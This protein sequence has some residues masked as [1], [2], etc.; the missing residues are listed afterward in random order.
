LKA[1]NNEKENGSLTYLQREWLSTGYEQA[2]RFYI[3]INDFA[4]NN[5]IRARC[6]VTELG[7]ISGKG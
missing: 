2:T 5:F 1:K 7:R 4:K 6:K 3:V